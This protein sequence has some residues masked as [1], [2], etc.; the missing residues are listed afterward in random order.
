MTHWHQAYDFCYLNFYYYCRCTQIS[1]W[2]P[3]AEGFAPL[4][5]SDT[6]LRFS[7]TCA[8]MHSCHMHNRVRFSSPCGK[9]WVQRHRILSLYDFGVSLDPEAWFQLH[10]KL[11]RIIRQVAACTAYTVNH[12][13]GCHSLLTVRA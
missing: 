5:Y 10:Q 9:Y 13:I 2:L 4:T 6:C 11:L 8:A 1:M 12:H 3:P 7:T